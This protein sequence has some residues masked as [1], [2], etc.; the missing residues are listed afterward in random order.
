MAL[1]VSP[2]ISRTEKTQNIADLTRETC[3]ITFRTA[4]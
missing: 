4:S 3:N 2:G 1:K